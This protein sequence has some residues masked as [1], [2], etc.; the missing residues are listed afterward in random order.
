M[1]RLFLL[2]NGF[3][4]AHGLKTGYND[5]ILWYLKKCFENVDFNS[6]YEDELLKI[7]MHSRFSPFGD[8]HNFSDIIDYFFKSNIQYFLTN[9]SFKIKNYFNEFPNPYNVI[10]KS[11][12]LNTL[13]IK[14][15]DCHWV[16]IENE[17]YEMLQQ[18]LNLEN[19]HKKN[20]L[21]KLNLSMKSLIFFL[22]DYLNTIEPTHLNNE[23]SNIF[24]SEINKR[25]CVDFISDEELILK[26][27]LVL[28]FNYTNTAE[29]YFKPHPYHI[30]EQWIE[31]NYIHGRLGETSNP[32][33]FGFG[34]ELDESYNKMES[35][36]IKGFLEYIKS[37]WYFRTTNY[38]NLIRFIES[39][40]YQVSVLGHSC[41][42]SD[43]TM[44]N[45]IFEHKNC[46]SIKIF[47]H[48]KE[49]G[50]HN[51]NDLTQEISRHFKDKTAMRKKVVNFIYSSPM[52]QVNIQK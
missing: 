43:R 41:G 50:E 5:F 2:G 16:N 9:S 7:E 42:L 21:D 20:E 8:F 37:F 3:D 19:K 22:E 18:A 17:Y 30:N 29:Y 27:S 36:K 23:Y 26:E 15:K 39:D 47:Y 33:I 35:E 14:C 46:K 24:A 32:L 25:E 6:C 45:M 51:F 13:L 52:P 1:N 4:L 48:Q 38:H 40:N 12:L 28:N 44:L 31:V 49:T 11:K 10:V 34:D